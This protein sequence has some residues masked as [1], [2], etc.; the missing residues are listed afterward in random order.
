MKLKLSIRKK[1]LYG[2]LLIFTIALLLLNAVISNMLYK[3]SETIIKN[4]M[5]SF[6]KYSREYVKQYLLLKN[7]TENSVFQKD[8]ERLVQELSSNLIGNISLYNEEGLFLY[9]A[10]GDRNEYIIT[11]TNPSKII[12]NSSNEDVNLALQNKA[13]F[14][15]NLIDKR[16]WV[17]FSFPVFINGKSLGIIRLSKDYSALF[18]ANQRVLTS[19]TVF[20]LFLFI[21]IFVFSY[22]LS[23]KIVRPLSDVQKAFTDVANGNY[24]TKLVVETG[25]EIEELTN[26][27]HEMKTQIKENITTIETEKLKVIQLEKSRREFFNNV[28]HELKTPLTTI[29]GYAQILSDKDFNDPQFLAKAA[30]RIKTESDRLHQMVIEVIELSKRDHQEIKKV[31]LTHII[32]QSVEDL[33]VKATKYEMKITSNVETHLLVAGR[34][35]KLRELLLNLLDN[36]IKYGDKHSVIHIVGIGNSEEIVLHITNHCQYLSKQ[37]LEKVFEPFYQGS[38]TNRV[39]KGSSGLGLFICKQIVENHSGTITV[40]GENNLVTFSVKLPI[41]QQLGNIY[42]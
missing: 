18:E 13:A 3:N 2:F 27:F 25:D 16:T 4:D 28:T 41:W 15:I 39:E 9:E 36:A 19:L 20:T 5:V 42:E 32:K 1:F 37:V 11:N 6:Q 7:L 31:D 38:K 22:I 12:E 21:A 40:Q 34:E 35:N 30:G 10:V 29:S 24:E 23:N 17:N 26:C 8:G 14:T 33:Q